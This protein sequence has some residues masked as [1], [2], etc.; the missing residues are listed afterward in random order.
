MREYN[1]EKLKLLGSLY[2]LWCNRNDGEEKEMAVW[3]RE[4]IT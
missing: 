3:I 2:F 1:Y 4:S